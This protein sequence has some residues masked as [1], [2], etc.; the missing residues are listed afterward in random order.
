MNITFF[1]SLFDGLAL[2][3]CGLVTLN[4]IIDFSSTMVRVVAC[5]LFSA[6]PLPEPVVTKWPFDPYGAN[7]NEIEIK[8]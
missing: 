5:R 7:F 2:T 4:G 8:C 6:K 1:F 3:H